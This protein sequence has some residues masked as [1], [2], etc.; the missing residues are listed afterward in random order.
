MRWVGR[1][2]RGGWEVAEV[3]PVCRGCDADIQHAANTKCPL[4]RAHR[5]VH[6]CTPEE[7]V[8]ATLATGSRPRIPPGFRRGVLAATGMWGQLSPKK[9]GTGT[10][11]TQVY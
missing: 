5:C 11:G 4:C 10:T 7:W 1:V 8:G 9:R 6:R 2:E 3:L